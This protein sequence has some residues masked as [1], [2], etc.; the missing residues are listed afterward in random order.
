VV[1]RGTSQPISILRKGQDQD[2]DPDPVCL[3]AAPMTIA[4]DAMTD[5]IV[6]STN[7]MII[8]LC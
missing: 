8:I 5:L 7:K 3:A 1:G 2:S 4:I 6:F